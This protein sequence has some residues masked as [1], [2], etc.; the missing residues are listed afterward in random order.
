MAIRP[1]SLVVVVY[2]SP[3]PRH[4]RRG[5]M[6]VVVVEMVVMVVEA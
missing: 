2:V 1:H 6:S 3:G 4:P 5:G